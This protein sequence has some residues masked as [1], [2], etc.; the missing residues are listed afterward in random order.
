MAWALRTEAL[1]VYPVPTQGSHTAQM[2]VDGKTKKVTLPNMKLVIEIG[3]AKHLGKEVYKQN[4]EMYDKIESIYLHY[5]S[6][7]KEYITYL[8]NLI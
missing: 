3:N 5:W 4:K 6:Q 2:K 1:K 7:S 8:K